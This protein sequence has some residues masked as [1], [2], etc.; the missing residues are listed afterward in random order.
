MNK[1]QAKKIAKKHGLTNL[2]K[3]WIFKDGR[4]QRESN[5]IVEW[6]YPITNER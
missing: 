5:K 4:I 6:S 2:P 1:R 3:G